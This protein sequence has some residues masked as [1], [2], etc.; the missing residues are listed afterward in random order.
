MLFIPYK[1]NLMFGVFSIHWHNTAFSSTYLV[2]YPFFR[3]LGAVAIFSL[4]MHIS[5]T[6]SA[7]TMF[8]RYMAISNISTTMGTKIA[9]NINDWIPF[10]MVFII[11]VVLALIPLLF[12]IW[13]NPDSMEN[14]NSYSSFPFNSLKNH[15]LY[16]KT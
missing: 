13:I 8:T 9:G 14:I 3:A 11:L 15:N 6:K 5:W 1:S 16:C 10:N 4:F 2:T 7:A 12:L